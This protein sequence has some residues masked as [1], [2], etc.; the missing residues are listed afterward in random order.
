[1][2]LLYADMPINYVWPTSG[3]LRLAISDDDDVRYYFIGLSAVLLM[4][5]RK[6]QPCVILAIR[7]YNLCVVIH[8]H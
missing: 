8:L 1:M 3:Y 4:V 2:F 5:K 7:K 6:G